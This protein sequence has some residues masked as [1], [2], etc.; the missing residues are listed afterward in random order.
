MNIFQ[1]QI[2]APV[3]YTIAM[4]MH[5]SFNACLMIGLLFLTTFSFFNY[6]FI[7]IFV[8]ILCGLFVG[9]LKKPV[10]FQFYTNKT[11]SFVADIVDYESNEIGTY[12]I[13][14]NFKYEKYGDNFFDDTPVF[15]KIAYMKI[16]KLDENKNIV[17]SKVKAIG[18]FY[19]PVYQ[20]FYHKI[21][22]EKPRGVINEYQIIE[23][24]KTN[25]KEFFRKK[26]KKAFQERNANLLSAIF[27]SDTYSIKKDVRKTFQNAGISHLLGVSVL[28][29][30][31]ISFI[32]YMF[33]YYLFGV[34]WPTI[35]LKVP[36]Q[37]LGSFFS[38]LSII[39]YCF[40]I[41][42]EFPIVRSLVMSFLAIIALFFNKKR[43]LESLLFSF[44][45]ITTF[46]ENAIY[47]IGFQLSFISVLGII[48]FDKK[49]NSSLS[50]RLKSSIFSTIFASICMVPFAIYNFQSVNLQ[51]ILANIFA[52]PFFSFCLMP[53]MFLWFFL[54]LFNMNFFALNVILSFFLNVFYEFAVI[55]ENFSTNIE[56]YPINFEFLI[57][58]SI[59]LAFFA[60]I[61]EKIR[62]VFLCSGFGFVFGSIIQS[63]FYKKEYILI[64]PYG[65]GLFLKN[66]LIMYPKCNFIG[67]LWAQAYKLPCVDGKDT[68]YFKKDECKK[69]IIND[70]I[71]LIGYLPNKTG[72]YCKIHNTKKDYFIFYDKIS[73]KI[74]KIDL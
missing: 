11:T 27:L 22:K 10:E 46:F 33:F 65:V 26:I 62:Y 40:I 49:H 74:Q 67:K 31:I 16:E 23:A 47:N 55:F 2:L 45:I 69:L 14:K 48:S 44:A 37:I 9:S 66:E 5:I 64:H 63:Y 57:I 8:F 70:Q 28:N 25:L 18:R 21:A 42:F 7:R 39:G 15:P 6:F 60:A 30:S 12:L 53:L 35:A 24:D 50:G 61:K 58:F 4:Y 52:I 51:P 19:L 38:M 72:K 20:F 73:K 71:G 59:C 54:A 43:N 29:I 1:L 36:L 13:L 41:G 56:F 3:F 34:F 17:G 68:K 32:F